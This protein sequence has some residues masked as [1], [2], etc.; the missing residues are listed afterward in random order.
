MSASDACVEIRCPARKA[1]EQV[2][3]DA[4]EL[5]CPDCGA[6]HRFLLCPVCNETAQVDDK[7]GR[8]GDAQHDPDNRVHGGFVVVGTAG[9]IA[10]G[11]LTSQNRKKREI[12]TFLHLASQSGELLPFHGRMPTD[13]MRQS[14]PRLVSRFPQ[15]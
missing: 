11:M 7:V 13:A 2:P 9:D 14:F 5:N 10:M 6:H 8:Q 1:P 15:E 3:A 4:T 12:T